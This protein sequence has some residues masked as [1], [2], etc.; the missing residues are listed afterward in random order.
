MPIFDG[1]VTSDFMKLIRVQEDK[2][3]DFIDF[4]A[5]DFYDLKTSLIQYIKAVYPEDYKNFSESDLGVM[6]IEIVAYMGAVMSMKADMLANENFLATAKQRD[7]VRKMMELIGVSLKGPTAAAANAKITLASSPA[8][9]A[10]T[11]PIDQ[12]VKVISSPEDG[13]PLNYTIYKVNSGRIVDVNFGG[14]IEINTSDADNPGTDTLYS[15]LALLEGS[16]VTQSGTISNSINSR[17]ISLTE[18]PVIEGSVEVFI[19]DTNLSVSGAW[20]QVN[21]LYMASGA[22]DNIFQI[23]YDKNYAATVI[24]GDGIAG[25]TPPVGSQYFVVYRVGGGNRG[26]LGAEIINTP[27][28]VTDSGSTEIQGT[29]EN[30]SLATGGS[31]AES[32]QHAKRYGP[33]T[34]KQQNRLVTLEDYKA[35]TNRFISSTGATGKAVAATRKAYSSGNIIDIYTLEKASNFQLQKASPTYKEELLESMSSQVMITDEVVIVDGLVRTIDLVLTV[36]VDKELSSKDESIKQKVK[37]AAL[38][39]FNV[40]NNDFGKTFVL[41]DLSREIFK[42]P[43][44]RFSS[45]DNFK[46]DVQVEFNEIIQLNNL[47]IS[48]ELV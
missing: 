21:N 17:E 28:T 15:N 26:N 46:D 5:T 40:D 9:G 27:I 3:Q 25:R 20:R 45:V 29:L 30:T 4:A 34:F 36:R 48:I 22:S 16:L 1:N 12:R 32:L 38:S 33:L 42:I 7:S 8:A 14:D 44:V 35:H 11:I 41:G 31:E 43:E 39:F 13:A 47:Q 23:V 18:A 19:E 2:K 24:F 6:L 37:R 10:I